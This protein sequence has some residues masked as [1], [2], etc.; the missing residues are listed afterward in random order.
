MQAEAGF[1]GSALAVLTRFENWKPEEVAVLA[2]KTK[3][4]ARNR[5]IHSLFDLY[6]YSLPLSAPLRELRE[7]ELTR[8]FLTVS[9]CTGGSR[10]NEVSMMMLSGC[11]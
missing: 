5:S 6:V 1:E 2:A 4:D 8:L 3:N 7:K 11:I 10:K 9:W